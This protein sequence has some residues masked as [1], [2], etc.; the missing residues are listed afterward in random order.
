MYNTITLFIYIQDDQSVTLQFLLLQSLCNNVSP[1]KTGR[2]WRCSTTHD[3]TDT[4]NIV[5]EYRVQL[6]LHVLVR[7]CDVWYVFVHSLKIASRYM[8]MSKTDRTYT[9]S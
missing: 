4:M 1:S 3:S 2:V 9:F 6:L 5:R 7:Y 8:Y